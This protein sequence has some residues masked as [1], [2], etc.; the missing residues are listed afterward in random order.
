M[1]KIKFQVKQITEKN[2]TNRMKRRR[3]KK[4]TTK[5]LNVEIISVWLCVCL[6]S[7]KIK[8][9][10]CV[11]FIFVATEFRDFFF[12]FWFFEIDKWLKCENSG[13]VLFSPSLS[14]SYLRKLAPELAHT[15]TN[16]RTNQPT[17][18]SVRQ[19]DRQW[20]SRHVEP[21]QNK[22]NEMKI[23]AKLINSIWM[24]SIQKLTPTLTIYR[25]PHRRSVPFGFV[26]DSVFLFGFFLV[27]TIIS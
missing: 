1:F 17:S 24:K 4:K 3:K 14:T 12:F 22:R 11:R 9:E 26:S 13:L 18:Q 27:S 2:K 5:M 16:E 19:A 10:W 6:Y 15:Y 25:R 23:T 8:L 7:W 20:V 21:A